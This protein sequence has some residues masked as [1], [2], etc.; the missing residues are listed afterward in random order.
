MSE[1]EEKL[2]QVLSNPAEM[3][4]IMNIARSLSGSLGAAPQNGG[5][6]AQQAAEAAQTSSSLPALDLASMS[7]VLKDIDPKI[8]RLITR[9]A[10]EYASGTND[11]ATLL[12]A[13]KPY[14]KEDRR[15]KI[16]RAAELAKLA[17]LARVAFSEFSG[18]DKRV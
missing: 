17:K 15:E 4:K 14:L 11:K 1:L 12:N 5:K 6:P 3:E 18:G 13:M 8:F 10:G 9:L 7:T 16:D 2:N